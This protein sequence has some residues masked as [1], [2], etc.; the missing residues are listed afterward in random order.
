MGNN[1]L[2]FW[3]EEDYKN[4]FYQ[5]SLLWTILI[6]IIREVETVRKDKKD[7]AKENMNTDYICK[8]GRIGFN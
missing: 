7:S 6:F 8:N 2:I 3:I 5:R 4:D 1:F